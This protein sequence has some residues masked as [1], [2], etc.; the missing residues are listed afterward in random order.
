MKE[1]KINKTIFF[2]L[3][4]WKCMKKIFIYIFLFIYLWMYIFI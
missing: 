2:F 4:S 3:M 1:K